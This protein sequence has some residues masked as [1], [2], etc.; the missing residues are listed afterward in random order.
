VKV[1]RLGEMFKDE[2]FFERQLVDQKIEAAVGA[3]AEH[4][5]Q[6]TE[7]LRRFA[8]TG[9]RRAWAS[10]GVTIVGTALLSVASAYPWHL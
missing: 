6:L 10:A 8:T 3:E 9:R 4:H 2:R 1:D 7:A 5:A